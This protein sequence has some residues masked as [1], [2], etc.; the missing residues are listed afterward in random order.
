[1]D[2]EHIAAAEFFRHRMRVI[3]HKIV[4]M[5]IFCQCP[6]V[7]LFRRRFFINLDSPEP[8]GGQRQRYLAVAVDIIF[9]PGIVRQHDIG[10]AFDQQRGA[11]ILFG[12]PQI[13]IRQQIRLQFLPDP[14]ARMDRG[15]HD[16]TVS[17]QTGIKTVI[18]D[19]IHF[20]FLPTLISGSNNSWKHTAGW[21]HFQA[22]ERIFAVKSP[23]FR[24][25]QT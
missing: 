13:I 11:V 5:I 12:P 16:R 10:T 7:D 25:R 20:G 1:M 3:R 21:N 22:G 24:I 4:K 2:V 9:R 17:A 6:A 14:A 8:F 15:R 23:A 19:P 18:L